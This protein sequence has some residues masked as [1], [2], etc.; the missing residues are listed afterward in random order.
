[1]AFSIGTLY[2][3]LG[4]A[5]MVATQLG[6]ISSAWLGIYMGI[7]P[8]GFILGS[9]LVGR[10]GARRV[11]FDLMITG[12]VLTGAALLVGLALFAW[13]AAH[14]LAFFGPCFFIGL[15]NG[16]TM[17]A[18]N[19][20][21]L[22]LR[23]DIAGT[24]LGLAAALTGAGAGLVAFVSGLVVQPSNAHWVVLCMMLA[25]TALSLVAAIVLRRYTR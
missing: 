1:M 12:R 8:G 22:A 5:P 21:V 14:P 25:S 11:R 6:G 2:V 18:A 20:R 15:G 4:G 16:L 13:G 19:A 23:P 24:A 3:F 7:V 17:P 10:L 9:A